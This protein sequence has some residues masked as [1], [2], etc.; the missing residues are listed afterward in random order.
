MDTQGQQHPMFQLP[1]EELQQIIALVLRVVVQLDD[2][3]LSQLRENQKF[4]DE[5][6]QAVAVAMTEEKDKAAQPFIP[7][8]PEWTVEERRI[9]DLVPEEE[10]D[11]MDEDGLSFGRSYTRVN[12]NGEQVLY[13]LS[14]YYDESVLEAAKEDD[15]QPPA[16][17][18]VSVSM[19]ISVVNQHVAM[20]EG[21]SSITPKT[22][23][24]IK[25]NI[26]RQ[27]DPDQLTP[28]LTTSSQPRIS[29]STY[30]KGVG[31]ARQ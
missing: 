12:R 19:Y 21:G 25:G 28:S 30:L 11:Q 13:L 3:A 16:R 26:D 2:H 1:Q 8:E 24:V 5:V 17:E 29:W 27:E 4:V 9:E 23:E 15:I 10:L 7:P 22:W 14:E 31:N 20:V 6:A 18:R